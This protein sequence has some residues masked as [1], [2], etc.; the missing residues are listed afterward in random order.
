MYLVAGLGNPGNQYLKTFHNVGFMAVELLAEKYGVS[1]NKKGFGGIYGMTKINGEQ[2]IFLKP[3]TFMNLSGECIQK[4][5]AFYKIPTENFI[6]IY[7]D[8]DI[9]IGCIRVRANG[10]AGT[11]N[12]MRNIVQMLNSTSFPRVRIGT[13]PEGEY[14]LIDYVLSNIKKED[15]PRFKI[16]ITGAVNA[17]DEFIKGKK[18]DDIMSK[19]NGEKVLV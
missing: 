1:F 11:H 3:Q 18:I 15:E 4:A 7:D 9:K 17:V 6:V 12:G 19:Y 5:L 13:K 16:S 10:T 8:I 2:V 14:E